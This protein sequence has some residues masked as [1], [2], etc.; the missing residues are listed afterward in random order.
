MLEKNKH[1][2]SHLQNAWNKYG[3]DKFEFLVIQQFNDDVNVELVLS[4]EQKLLDEHFGKDYCYNQSSFARMDKEN[5]RLLL[6]KRMMGYRNPMFGKTHSEEARRKISE[7]AKKRRWNDEQ[8]KRISE[9]AKGRKHSKET[10]EKLRELNVGRKHTP[11]MR[12]WLTKFHRNRVK[13]P[14]FYYRFQHSELGEHVLSTAEFIEKFGLSESTLWKLNKGIPV[15]SK[16]WKIVERIL[17]EQHKSFRQV[18][19]IETTQIV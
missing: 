2:N 3:K 11:E 7:S 6:S 15:D 13:H 18:S 14:R 1:E 4:E 17:F 12:D 10:K 16:G 9:W 5:V 8:R 19:V